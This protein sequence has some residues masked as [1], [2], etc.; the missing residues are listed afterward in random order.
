[1]RRS[2]R[3]GKLQTATP[4]AQR[5]TVRLGKELAVIGTSELSADKAAAALIERFK[6][7]LD[8]KDIDG[9]AI[10]TKVDREAIFRAATKAEA[11]SAAAAAH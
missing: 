2:S 8:D 9:L 11:A 7:P 4:V 10:L 1:V 6:T 3:L 5:A